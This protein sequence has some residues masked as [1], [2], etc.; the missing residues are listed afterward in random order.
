MCYFE[1]KQLFNVE[2]FKST[3]T[4]F[5]IIKKPINIMDKL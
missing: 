5:C 4:W 1:E 3:F 2:M